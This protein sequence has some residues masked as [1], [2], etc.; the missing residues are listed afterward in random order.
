MSISGTGG[1]YSSPCILV[2]MQPPDVIVAGK[3][4][5]SFRDGLKLHLL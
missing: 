4:K 3:G 5:E 1:G 2:A